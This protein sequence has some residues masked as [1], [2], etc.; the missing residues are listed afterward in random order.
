MK[1]VNQVFH[2]IS[3]RMFEHKILQAYKDHVINKF[4]LLLI[5][6]NNI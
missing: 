4:I 1:Q 6:Y 5:Y 2:V 3:I